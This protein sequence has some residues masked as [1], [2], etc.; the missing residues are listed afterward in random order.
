VAAGSAEFYRDLV[1]SLDAIF[2][3]AD[4]TTLQ[5]TA[6]SPNAEALLGYPSSAWTS[7]PNFWGEII[8]PDDREPTLVTRMLNIKRCEDHR[9]DYR[10]ITADGRTR[11]IRDSVRLKCE[12][13]Q[14]KQVCGV[15]IDVTA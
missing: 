12:H 15:M 14:P 1:E 2:W 4:P 8:H 3:E 6:V 13:G 9:L 5:F 10:V 7:N 11:W